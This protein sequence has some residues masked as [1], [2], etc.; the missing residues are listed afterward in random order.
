M[1]QDTDP[2]LPNYGNLADNPR[3]IDINAGPPL[4]KM[5]AE[6][7]QV[8]IDTGQLPAIA[9]LNDRGSDMHHSNALFYDAAL[10]QIIVSTRELSEIWIID[11][12]ISS[13]QAAG[14]AGDLLYR[15]GNPANYGYSEDRQVGLG[16]Q[17]DINR[18]PEGYPGAG[19][20]MAFSNDA[21]GTSPPHSEV[22]EFA[23]PTDQNGNYRLVAGQPFGPQ[24]IVWR[25]SDQ[26]FYSPFISGTRRLANGNTFIDFG[27]Q[28][29]FI[30]VNPAGEI[31]WEY[32]SPYTGTV[33]LPD[34][35]APQP[36]GPFHYA[37]FRATF[38]PADDPA[39][40][41]K[42]LEPLVPQP[43]LIPINEDELAPFRQ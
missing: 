30:E 27:P 38:I 39:L 26:G 19:N 33:R 37:V 8:Q 4:P 41:G 1:V 32:W 35:S 24:S 22:I 5:T 9:T 2:A 17:H 18:I 13:E 23:P 28:G 10:D 14:P 16:H 34:G 6:E 7:L 25:F 12:S 36:I 31:V 21:V 3:K 20:L 29:R 11:H 43:E 15:W 40:A 42:T